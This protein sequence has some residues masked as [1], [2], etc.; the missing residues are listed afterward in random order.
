MFLRVIL[1]LECIPILERLPIL[2]DFLTRGQWYEHLLI[3]RDEPRFGKGWGLVIFWT[4][5]GSVR[6]RWS[7]RRAQAGFGLRLRHCFIMLLS[8]GGE[9]GLIWSRRWTGIT[10]GN[11]ICRAGYFPKKTNT[12]GFV[13]W[14]FGRLLHVLASD[15]H[16]DTL[17]SSEIVFY[18]LKK[19]STY[20]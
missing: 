7:L 9:G 19:N 5:S 12:S 15:R 13:C 20:F 2:Q 17:M 3:W 14:A 10:Q 4:A 11:G 18:L 8:A 16:T 6:T 1:Y